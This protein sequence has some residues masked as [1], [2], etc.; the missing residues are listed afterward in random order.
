MIYELKNK[1]LKNRFFKTILHDSCFMIQSKLPITRYLLLVIFLLLL[2]APTPTNALSLVSVR[3]I[4]TRLKVYTPSDH[5][6]QFTMSGGMFSGTMQVDFSNAVSDT[7]NVDYQDIDL[8][9]GP[10]NLE[11]EQVV[12]AYPSTNIWGVS[13]NQT[14]KIL[15]LTYPTAS[16]TP[17]VTGDRVI[18]KIGSN[19]SFGNTTSHALRQ[20]TNGIQGGSKNISISVGA[21]SGDLAIPLVME[22]SIGVSGDLAHLILTPI[23]SNKILITILG[24]IRNAT[25][26]H[27]ERSLDG[28]KYASIAEIPQSKRE[29]EDKNVEQLTTYFYRLVPYNANG[30]LGIADEAIITTP[31]ASALPPAIPSPTPSPQAQPTPTQSISQSQ[32]EPFQK[33]PSEVQEKKGDNIQ[34]KSPEK[35]KQEP[36]ATSELPNVNQLKIEKGVQGATFFWKNPKN[37]SDFTIVVRRSEKT[38]PRS[39]LEGTAQ[40]QGSGE[41]FSDSPLAEE[42]TYYY[43]VFVLDKNLHY[44]SGSF[45]SIT[46]IPIQKQATPAI[47]QVSTS[48]PLQQQPQRV[49]PNSPVATQEIAQQSTPLVITLG[50]PIS[51]IADPQKQ[52]IFSL[53]NTNSDGGV[54]NL[55]IEIPQNLTEKPIDISV[56]SIVQTDIQK[57]DASIQ[58]PIDKEVVGQFFQITAR[59]DEEHL[60]KFTKT[61]R[62]KFKYNEK[63]FKDFQT[64]TIHVAYWD[65]LVE[66][67]IFL[68]NTFVDVSEKTVVV[69]VDV[70]HFTL[71]GVMADKKEQQHIQPVRKVTVIPQDGKEIVFSQKQELNQKIL[72]VTF[73]HEGTLEE[74]FL[75]QDIWQT[76]QNEY[77]RICLKEKNIPK[78]TGQIILKIFSSQYF[79]VYD[80]IKKCYGTTFQSPEKKGVYSGSIKIVYN[81]DRITKVPLTFQVVSPLEE[82]AL[83]YGELLNQGI[84][85]SLFVLAFVLIWLMLLAGGWFAFGRNRV[86]FSENI[87]INE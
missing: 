57:F 74:L 23:S 22:D 40:Y 28:K 87:N 48:A 34:N 44:S 19:A 9:Y 76:T 69:E 75:K 67:W 42:R 26:Y 16:G 36:Q 61:I 84:S 5:T 15:T 80:P 13:M 33:P 73:T 38:F 27:I 71:F 86:R 78:N 10:P 59:Q 82:V 31:Q 49:V 8:A 63:L 25:S 72:G 52:T 56:R 50:A 17:L 66:Q 83:K 1:I 3:D 58:L 7:N 12:L 53:K 55:N 21:D 6:I 29:A 77:V 65:P 30:A 37:I 45:Q 4:V 47:P 39:P 2:I 54:E 68:P 85:F 81:D 46:I 79:L 60:K 70:N 51:G 35:E 32:N 64:D 62:L 24:G 43:T 20:M 18:I 11:R 41:N 14:T